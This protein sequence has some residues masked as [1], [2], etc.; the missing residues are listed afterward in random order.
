MSRGVKWEFLHQSIDKSINGR[1]TVPREMGRLRGRR[2][3]DETLQ[4]RPVDLQRIIDYSSATVIINHSQINQAFR[5]LDLHRISN[6]SIIDYSLA[7][8]YHIDQKPR[9]N[10][11]CSYY[12]TNY[13][14]LTTNY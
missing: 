14:L 12:V 6:V 2:V 9:T 7:I 5:H 3:H 1:A 4:A 11:L 13:V 8:V 10:Y